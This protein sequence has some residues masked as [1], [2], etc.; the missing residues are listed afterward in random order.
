MLAVSSNPIMLYKVL[1]SL[2]PEKLF[3]IFLPTI[4]V[5]LLGV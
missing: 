3:L 4:Y 2:N 5:K 1:P